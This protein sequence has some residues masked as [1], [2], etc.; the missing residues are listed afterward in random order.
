MRAHKWV[1]GDDGTTFKVIAGV[2]CLFENTPKISA[3]I[4]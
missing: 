3:T 2:S 1:A 4:Y